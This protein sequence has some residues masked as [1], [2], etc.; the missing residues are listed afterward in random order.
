PTIITSVVQAILHHVE[1]DL[2]LIN[3]ISEPSIYAP[4][5]PEIQLWEEGIPEDAREEAADLG[6][7]WGE[8]DSIGNI[9]MLRADGEYEGAAD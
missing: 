9:N 6:N 5:S 2:P 7:E 8:M 1:Y 4:E 3:A